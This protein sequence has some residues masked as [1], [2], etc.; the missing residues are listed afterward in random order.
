MPSVS[1]DFKG[2]IKLIHFNMYAKPWLYKN[3][4]M[5]EYFWKH[6]KNTAYYDYLTNK[7]ADYDFVHRQKDM[8]AGER[9]LK[10]AT[11][12]TDDK[13]AFM[14]VLNGKEIWKKKF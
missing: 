6:A 3:V 5:E 12:I 4:T 8:S 9:L 10:T 11:K 14:H 1:G 7:R 2:E 13:N